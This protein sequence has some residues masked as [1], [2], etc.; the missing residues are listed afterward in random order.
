MVSTGAAGSS[1]SGIL[2]LLLLATT[3]ANLTFQHRVIGHRG[4]H[5]PL[6]VVVLAEDFVL[7]QVELVS[8]AEPMVALLTGEAL[9]MVDVVPG[10]HDH[11][12]GRYHL[13]AGRAEASVA[14]ESQIVPLA[15]HQIALGV[16]GGPDLAEP[17]IAAAAL[18]AVLVP[19]QV[20]RPQQE[21]VLDVLFAAGAKLLLLLL[22][23]L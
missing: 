17:A 20:Q 19:Q 3:L 7:A 5:Q 10:P 6:L 11:L 9:Q 1:C 14:K 2:L 4:K 13:V 12:E 15:E 21:P 22:L 18:E 16:Q 8:D 23:W